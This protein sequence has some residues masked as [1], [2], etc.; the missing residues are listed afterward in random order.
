[1]AAFTHLRG[2]S[3]RL[4]TE[5]ELHTL[6]DEVLSTTM[7][8]QDAHL[9]CVQ[10]YDPATGS[11]DVV[12]HC[13]FQ[14]ESLEDVRHD[15]ATIGRQ[16]L[17][18]GARVVVEDVSNDPDFAPRG[19]A[20]EAAGFRGAQSTPMFDRGGAPL[21]TICTLFREEHH[22]RDRE[23]RFTDLYA[24]LTAQLIEGQRTEKAL[25]ASEERFRRY[26][27]LGLIGMAITSPATGCLQVNDELCRILGY[28]R[29]ELL[30]KTW[31]EMTHPDDLAADMAQFNR[32]MAGEIDGYTLDKRWIRK[33]GRIIDSVMAAQCMR[34]PDGSVDC[35]VGLLL[36][37]TEREC[38]EKRLAES[39]RLF[40][41]LVESIPH[42]VWTIRPG[43]AL[44]YWNRRLEDY[45]GI[46]L[47]ELRHGAW[48]S[49]HPDDLERV[50]ATWQ[51]AWTHGTPYEMEQRIR[52]RDGYYRRFVCRGE[53]VL[54]EHG[55][56]VEW[57]GTNTDVEERRHSEEA[58]H[59]MRSELAHVARATTMG[60]L[61]ASI[62]HEV[63][64]PLAAI[65]ANAGACARWLA[66]QP[67][68]MD[69]ARNAVQRVIRDADR[70]TDVVA[71]I[72][73]FLRRDESR[74]LLGVN[75]VIREVVDITRREVAAHQ[76]VLRLDLEDGLPAV[77]ADRIQ[78]QQ[79]TLNLM[80]N[81]L[82][83]MDAVIGRRRLLLIRTG[84]AAADAVVVSVC[85]CGVG[86]DSARR[87]RIFDAFYTTKQMGLGMGL[88][89]SRSIVE[90]HGGR[91]WATANPERGETFQFTLPFGPPPASH[92]QTC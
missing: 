66:A 52:G 34:R 55:L 41:L 79:V 48:A 91:L 39:E 29:A 18:R 3:A 67:P 42:H 57:F 27:D 32:V 58:L 76:V 17:M 6:L 61:A 46:T 7:A 35:F 68:E 73:A 78:L 45:T 31:P 74:A 92:F 70:A 87:E 82:E 63:N 28:E 62:S 38:A 1:M 33:D 80:L 26:F 56:P 51:Q 43:G 24:R 5:A 81:A 15:A 44:S 54:D 37:T 40:R 13:G 10:L 12:A 36:D 60:E 14:P 23:L 4:F 22:P 65:V 20:T 64:Q 59:E 69:E 49:V 71:R 88:A 89:I 21:G 50:R 90:A 85:D 53:A 19:H 11:L 86:L 83:A 2:Q 77:I 72:R 16:A 8:L 75:E 30:K 47:E 9:G 25:R 84:R